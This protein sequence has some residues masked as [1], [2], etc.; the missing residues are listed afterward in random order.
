MGSLT[1]DLAT[2]YDE[3]E[4]EHA[5][6][7]FDPDRDGDDDAEDWGDCMHPKSL[8]EMGWSELR[9]PAK[10]PRGGVKASAPG[11]C[12]LRQGSITVRA[13]GVAESF[14]MWP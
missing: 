3:K 1:I 11:A 4:Y 7:F 9:C 12:P 5:C 14:K 2:V 8:S 10:G 6:P 13:K